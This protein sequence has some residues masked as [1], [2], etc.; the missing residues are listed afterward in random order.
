MKQ[1]IRSNSVPQAH[2]TINKNR[3]KEFNGKVYLTDKTLFEIELFNPTQYRMGA[4][5]KFNGL[6][7]QHGYL[8]IEPGQR[9]HLDRYFDTNKRF[10]FDTYEIENSEVAKKAVE[11]NGLIQVEFYREKE[12]IQPFPF[13]T[14]YT[15]DWNGKFQWPTY[16]GTSDKLHDRAHTTLTT[17]CND[18]SVNYCSSNIQESAAG[19]VRSP[20][21]KRDGRSFLKNI[22]EP[23]M[24]LMERSFAAPLE[25]GK[26]N[27]SNVRSEQEFENV[28]ADFNSYA[29]TRVDLRLLPLSQQPVVPADLVQYCTDCG[30]KFKKGWKFCPKCGGHKGNKG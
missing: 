12:F 10:Q 3:L 5:F 4:K 7:I 25:T 1:A 18:I 9:F 16:Y 14:T 30:M 6:Y 29:H 8:I 26:I 2:I 24:D 15:Y 11:K 21:L 13:K 17:G 28:S 19:E 27:K 22:E 23:T 20:S